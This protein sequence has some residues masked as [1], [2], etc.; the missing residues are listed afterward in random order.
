MTPGGKTHYG[1]LAVQVPR[2]FVM[3]NQAHSLGQIK[4]RGGVEG[5]GLA[6]KAVAQDEDLVA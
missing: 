3:V 2:I 1:N 4:E 5:R 6:D